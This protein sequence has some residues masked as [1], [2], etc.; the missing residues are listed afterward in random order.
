MNAVTCIDRP[1]RWRPRLEHLAAVAIGLPIFF[2]VGRGSVGLSPPYSE[3]AVESVTS[4]PFSVV[5]LPAIFLLLL[6]ATDRRRSAFS[7]RL[8]LDDV[9]VLAY[10]LVNTGAVLYGAVLSGLAEPAAVLTYMQT[11][12]PVVGYFAARFLMNRGAATRVFEGRERASEFL[13]VLSLLTLTFL[14]LYV[15]QTLVDGLSSFRLSIITDHIGPF[16]NY[17]MKRFFPLY[18]ALATACMVSYAIYSRGGHRRVVAGGLALFGTMGLVLMHSRTA[19]LFFAAATAILGLG[20]FNVQRLAV[21]RRAIGVAAFLVLGGLVAAVPISK[22]GSKSLARLYQTL[23]VLTDAGP[24]GQG[25]ETRLERMRYGVEVGFGSAF[26]SGFQIERR[27]GLR[28]AV[29]TESGYLDTVARAGPLALCLILVVVARSLY[30]AARIHAR[31]WRDSSEIFPVWA[32]K[33]LL[34]SLIAFSLVGNVWVNTFTEPY[35]GPAYW[36]LLGTT[37]SLVSSTYRGPVPPQSQPVAN[38]TPDLVHT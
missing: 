9:T 18:V 23:L 36:F 31:A 38:R 12:F 19:L 34:G 27:H 37:V 17:K 2:S 4:V 29:T 28:R 16:Y 11:I 10:V 32:A 33:S 30:F 20:L 22:V 6:L 5:G 24:L 21:K 7:R 15:V 25:D 14:L 35:L 13:M 3:R 26:G 8:L 1:G